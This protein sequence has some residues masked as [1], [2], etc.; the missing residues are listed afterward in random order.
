MGI[1]SLP[2][3]LT[4]DLAGDPDFLKALCHVLMNVHLVE[5]M[6]TCPATGREFPVENEIP[7]MMLDEEESEHVR[8]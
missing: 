6:L 5:G 7:N 4:D 8:L 3:R 2:P 1:T